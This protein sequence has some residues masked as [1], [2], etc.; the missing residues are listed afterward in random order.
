MRRRKLIVVETSTTGTG[1]DQK[2]GAKYQLPLG[3]ANANESE[4]A[5]GRIMQAVNAQL[6]YSGSDLRLMMHDMKQR[7]VVQISFPE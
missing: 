5:A 7:K 3:S 2:F 1:K 6:D 4:N